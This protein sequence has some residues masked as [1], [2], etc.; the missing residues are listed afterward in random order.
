MCLD[1]LYR[2]IFNSDYPTDK[3]VWLYEG[4]VKLNS[5][6]QATVTLDIQLD[7][8]PY[9]KGCISLD[10]WQ[11]SIGLGTTRLASG[12]NVTDLIIANVYNS[13]LDLNLQRHANATVKYR[14]WGVLSENDTG[15]EAN[16]NNAISKTKLAFSTD[17]NYP[18]LIKEGIAKSGETVGL[19][20][21]GIPLI[22]VSNLSSA[23]F[24]S[25][26][27]RLRA[28]RTVSKSILSS[29]IFCFLAGSAI[30]VLLAYILVEDSIR[31]STI[32]RRFALSEEPVE[33]LSIRICA[34][35]SSVS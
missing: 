21:L 3:V 15:I 9:I 10:D 34:I 2:F 11:T 18:R 7:R 24:I 6:G 35:E 12:G 28:L 23:Q 4:S 25:S 32:L 29:M 13:E 1:T 17:N 22:K 8:V 5:S 14:L 27:T 19:F 30:A 31:V 16:R 20:M 33:V 26:I